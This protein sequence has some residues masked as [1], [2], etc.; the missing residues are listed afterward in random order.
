MIVDQS[1][2]PKHEASI[3]P[4]VMSL[5]ERQKIL[6]EWNQTER[7]YPRNKCMHHL[8]EEQVQQSPDARAVLCAGKSLTYS[9]LNTQANQL[10]RELKVLGVGPEVLVGVCLNR[11]CEML[12]ALFGILKA[13]GAYVPL[14]P[15]YP[16]DRLEFIA[17]DS[18]IRVL[19]TQREIVS[20][21]QGLAK[22]T[23]VLF[24]EDD[25]TSFDGTDL[26]ESSSSTQ[27]AY[28]IYTSGST[29]R[30]KGVAIEHRNAVSFLHWIG[31]SFT[32]EELTGVLG[33]TSICFDL[34]VFELFGPLS[35]GGTVILVD[36]ALDLITCESREEVTLLN[37]VPS[38][39]NAL[40]KAQALPTSVI[41][42]N[43][44][45][46][47]LSP[48][49]VDALYD[50]PSIRSVNDLYG[51]SETTTYSTWARREPH[52][53]ATIGRP[54]ANTQVYVLDE[55]LNPV[56]LGTLGDMWIGGAGVARGYWK[57]PDL[58]AERFL[59]NPFTREYGGRIYRTG[60]LAR[61]RPDGQLEYLGRSDHQV[62]IRGY[63][64]ELGEIEST[65]DDVKDIAESAVVARRKESH[66]EADS[67]DLVLV[68]FVVPANGTRLSVAR[69]RSELTIKL[70][71]Y[72][73]PSQFVVMDALPLTT[74]G[75]L[76]QKALMTSQIDVLG[77]VELIE[78][79]DYVAPIN[80]RERVIAEIWQSV[81]G[82]ERV[83]RNESFLDLGGHSLKAI[84]IASRISEQCGHTVP[85]RWVFEYPTIEKLVVKLDGAT[86]T[87][88]TTSLIQPADRQIPLK[89]SFGQSGLWL[90][91]SIV[92]DPATYNEPLAY[93][94]S[95]SVDQEKLIRALQATF[96]RHES[97]R[98]A[99]V[100]QDETLIQQVI[101]SADLSLP[102]RELSLRGE[103]SS[104]RESILNERLL[105]EVRRPFDLGKA[106]L[107]RVLLIDLADDD[108]AL[109]VTFHHSII[110]EW[111][112]RL[113]SQELA[114]LYSCGADLER[115]DLPDLPIQYVDYSHWQRQRLTGNHREQLLSYWKNQLA[116]LP[117]ALE[118]PSDKIRPLQPTG[119]GARYEFPLDQQVVMGLRQLA[120]DEEMTVFSV[121]LASFQVWLY[122][123]TGQTDIIVGT[124]L[125]D[126]E[127]PEVQSL[128]GYFLNMLPIRSRLE[129]ETSFREVL[130]QVHQTI[131]SAF[132][133]ADLPF[134]QMVELAVKQREPG[135]NPVYQVMFVLMEESIEKLAFG[136]AI[137]RPLSAPT[138]TSKN[139]LTLDIQATGD[140]WICRWEYA[141][142]LLSPDEV[143]RMAD[144]F[145]EL[146]RSIAKE[147]DAP[148]GRLKL[149][150]QQERHRILV[151]WN[152]TQRDYPRDTCVHQ[153]FEEQV[154]RTPLAVA[155]EFED[156]SLTYGELNARANQLAH[157]LQKSGIGLETR[158]GICAER[159]FEMIIGLLAILK[160]GGTYVPLDPHYP[161]ERLNFLAADTGI[162]SILTQRHL[163]SRWQNADLQ[164]IV[165]DADHSGLSNEP[166][167]NIEP[168]GNLNLKQSSESSAY[169]IYTSGSTGTPKGVEVLH[170]GIVRLVCGADYAQLDE[171]QSVLQLAVLSFDASTFEIW[172]PLLHGGRCV[173]AP[174]Q[175]PEP[176]ELQQLLRQKHVR[177]LWLTSSLFNTLADGH[178]TVLEGIEQLL[179]GGEA[180]SVSHIRRAQ[181]VL[182]SQTQLINGYGPTESTTFACCHRLPSMIPEDCPSIPIGRPISNTTAYVLDAILEP[183]PIGVTGELYLGGDGLA[184]GYLNQPELTAE[185]F[186]PDPFSDQT[187]PR[188]YRTGDLVHW[189][190]DGTIEFLGRRDQQIKLRGFR[191][192]TGEIEAVL[193]RHPTVRQAVVV[194]RE[195]R[196]G[197]KRLVGYIATHQNQPAT[198]VNELRKYLH[199]KLP[200]YMIPTALFTL[201]DLPLTANGKVDKRVLPRPDITWHDREQDFVSPRNTLEE[202]LASAWS[203]VLGI[204]QVSVHDNFFELGGHS[205]LAVR[206]VDEIKSLSGITIKVADLFR[207]ATVAE[208]AESLSDSDQTAEVSN[209]GQYLE[210]IRP[211]NG[212]THLVIVGAKL[213]VPLEM[214]PP[215]I[216]VWWLKMDGLHVWPPKHI[217]LPH[218]AAIHAQELSREIPSGTILLCGHSYGGAVAIEVAQQL[219][220]A[221]K[222]DVKLILLEPTL[223]SSRNEPIIKKAARKLKEF[224]NRDHSQNFR[225][226]SRA[227]YKT[228]IG[229]VK[230]LIINSRKST[231]QNVTV[232]NRWD[233]MEPFFLGNVSKFRF[234]VSTTKEVHLIKTR[235]YNQGSFELLE[236]IAKNS[237][238]IHETPEHM[239]HYSMAAPQNSMV[240]MRIALKLI[241]R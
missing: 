41:T 110:D 104:I 153:L 180:L 206:V 89:A 208:L 77:G 56:P 199:D 230:N 42:V 231:D 191:I 97:L 226:L 167:F 159:S 14:D 17:H 93:R 44:A 223:W 192:E 163:V 8:F 36:Q 109:V 175:F 46:E 164:L 50:H 213:R 53:P 128:I 48:A 160:A 150:G 11:S 3:Y 235:H 193:L 49:L 190:D 198:F 1:Q 26:T 127:R 82:L 174:V 9:D 184:R 63:R 51:P 13:G 29:G 102:W 90:V 194:L 40:L 239:D 45:G 65:L 161:A 2:V 24:M 222:Y 66:A 72:M 108:R 218:Q 87:L 37:T 88:A 120:R 118:L 154:Q 166:N 181:Q 57:R 197:D 176:E 123:Y 62:K 138:G 210:S 98:L 92:P 121:L 238:Q 136:D 131:W 170:R 158:V 232:E 133:H 30:P 212:N 204:K 186:L 162:T 35:W 125:A 141:T 152:Q 225:E 132:S 105:E 85:L 68:A 94:I 205:L 71:D 73:V 241:D 60:D 236:Q 64:V 171:T 54:I 7:D 228:T 27:L 99:L 107:W 96:C 237:L 4:P 135:R 5:E 221:E 103:S 202:M 195:D 203:S 61:W 95:G 31:E 101:D 20:K 23:S 130:R 124:P 10:A 211:A 240:W 119:Q 140:Q 139:D 25:R 91:H 115:A 76:D 137:G 156:Q 28:L 129:A 234:P 188:M 112:L 22:E 47:P 216:T 75:K 18:Q 83:G 217:D 145:T 15:N 78:A 196:P 38:V 80:D 86:D 220:Q 12:V 229:K 74:N 172:G 168:D 207:H 155:V 34:S 182:G 227:F 147:T 178:L 215:E 183:V 233:Y 151:E 52:Q 209:Y 100:K 179:V 143:A 134:E 146:L 116:D 16:A 114:A 39:A 59:T 169:V 32:D 177:T 43:L 185:K 79:K 111:S 58:T 106:P 19:I 70:P 21:R 69:L 187:N 117:P 81:L 148:I 214:L 144:H 149:M 201:D 122:R 33:A 67:D 224:K 189:R 200:D 173:L 219:M 165:L 126:R 6:V 84:V 55:R 157:D 113:F 142:D